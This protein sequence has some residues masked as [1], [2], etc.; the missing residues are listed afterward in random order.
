VGDKN[1]EVISLVQDREEELFGNTARAKTTQRIVTDIK[2][3]YDNKHPFIALST[4]SNYNKILKR[5]L[6]KYL[7]EVDYGKDGEFTYRW[8]LIDN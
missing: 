7:S 5:Q 6:N 1:E 8:E 3:S 2:R 4:D